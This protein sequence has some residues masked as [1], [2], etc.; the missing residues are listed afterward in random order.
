MVFAPFY[1]ATGGRMVTVMLPVV[2]LVV[3]TVVSWLPAP[4]V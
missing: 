1:S 3:D 2:G 4:G